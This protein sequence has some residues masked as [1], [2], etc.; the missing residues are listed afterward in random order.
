MDG[1]RRHDAGSVGEAGAAA[2]RALSLHLHAGAAV[3]Q[4]LDALGLQ[5]MLHFGDSLREA[6][7]LLKPFA[8]HRRQGVHVNA[9]SP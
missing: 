9:A 8:F 1:R 3:V 4:E 2:V 7:E 6:V 5:R